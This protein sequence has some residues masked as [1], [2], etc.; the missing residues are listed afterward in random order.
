MCV[1]VC[2]YVCVCVCTCVRAC[3]WL[4]ICIVLFSGK[5]KG[6][7]GA[8]ACFLPIIEKAVKYINSEGALY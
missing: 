6:S 3:V 7:R 1:C 2:V 5:F 8:V 4:R